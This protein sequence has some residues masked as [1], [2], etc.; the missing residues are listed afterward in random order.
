MK[1]VFVRNSF[2]IIYGFFIIFFKNHF[3]LKIIFGFLWSIWLA[4]VHCILVLLYLSCCALFM[5]KVYLI[6][7]SLI[8]NLIYIRFFMYCSCFLYLLSLC[9]VC[10]CTCSSIYFWT[11]GLPEAVLCNHPCQSVRPWSIGSVFNDTQHLAKTAC[12]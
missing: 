7:I 6:H 11:L 5:A 2:C 4:G 8:L 3:L 10:H 1:I 9:A 12:S